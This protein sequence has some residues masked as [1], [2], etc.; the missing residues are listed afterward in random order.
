MKIDLNNCFPPSKD[1]ER[2][3]LPKQ[4]E[5]LK[6]MLDAKGPKHIAYYGGYGSGKSVTLVVANIMLGVIYGGSYVIARHFMP[7]LR[8][9][10]MK[11][12]LELLPKELLLEHRVADAEIHIKSQK[13]KA[14]FY[15]VGL[16]DPGKLD[17]LTLSGASIDEASQ[18]TEEAFLKLQG[19][20]R[21]PTGLRKIL[22]AGNP[23]GHDWVYHYFIKQDFHNVKIKKDHFKMI[24]APSTEN[25]HLAEDYVENML[26]TYS[27]ERIQRDVMGSFDA[28]EGQ[29]YNEF[30]RNIHVVQPFAIPT[31][32]TRVIGIDH[33]YRNPSCW[34]W[35]AVDYDEN[36]YIYREFYEREWLI[37]EICKGNNK[38]NKPGVMSLMGKERIEQARI[39]PSTRAVRGASG[40]SDWDTY[41][42][43]L[44]KDFPLCLANNEKTA[45]IDRV[46]SFL[47]ISSVTNKPKLFI[48]GDCMNLI[49]ELSSYRYKELSPGQVGMVNEKEEPA[50][51]NDHACDALRYL[52]MSRPEAP[53]EKTS[54]W[55]KLKYNSLEGNLYRELQSWKKPKNNKDPFESG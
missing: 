35:G 42:D 54:I 5:F 24:V 38:I 32:W 29:V 27:P 34:L 39:D 7:E 37:E 4:K 55:K 11:L 47:K 30:I 17:S 46:K 31:E 14:V 48:F 18:T 50:K 28:F 8:R 2:G 20:L 43:N 49:D 40:L 36:V 6:N 16:D 15:F 22:L 9:T 41:V 52:I 10:T 44:P 51:V 12:F 19:R 3:P 26:S 45:G 21:E 53:K 33:G 25:I 1:G 13:G 23:K